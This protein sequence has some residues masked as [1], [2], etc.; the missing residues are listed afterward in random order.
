MDKTIIGNYLRRQKTKVVENFV[1][2]K[3]TISYTE[4]IKQT[5]QIKK[6]TGDEEI[7]RAFILT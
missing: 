7:V 3:S 1:F 5:R 2:E 4:A 6:I